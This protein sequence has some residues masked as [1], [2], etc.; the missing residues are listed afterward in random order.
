MYYFAY[1]SNMLTARL[2]ERVPAVRPAGPAWLTHHQLHFHLRGS[3]G[4]GKCN[5]LHTGQAD[6]IVHGVLFELDAARLTRLHAAEGPPYAFLELDVGT[7]EGPCRAAIYRGKPAYLDDT[8]VPYDWYCAF[9]VGGAREHGLPADYVETLAAVASHSDPDPLRARRN[10]RTL[11]HR[12]TN[13]HHEPLAES[14]R[15]RSACRDRVNDPQ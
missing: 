13:V 14:D 10:A 7:A 1:G 3:D 12:P 5:V 6:D 9:V 8:L 15:G 4:S 2:A 11:A